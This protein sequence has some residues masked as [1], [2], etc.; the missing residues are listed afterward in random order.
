MLSKHL[1]ND[2][3]LMYMIYPHAKANRKGVFKPSDCD[4]FVQKIIEDF[5]IK[6][7]KSPTLLFIPEDHTGK[8]NYGKHII[9]KREGRP[10]G[11]YYLGFQTQDQGR[12]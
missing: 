2:D 12:S 1:A 8:E 7:G 11:H 10:Y 4:A 6:M 3:K 5:K 9:V